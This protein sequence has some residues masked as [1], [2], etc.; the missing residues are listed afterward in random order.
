MKIESIEAIAVD[1]PLKRN[2]GGS[3][4]SVLK[5]STVIT[6]MRTDGG[7]TSE[8]YNGDNREHGGGIGKIGEQ[9]KLVGDRRIGNQPCKPADAR[10]RHGVIGRSDRADHR[11]DE[12]QQIGDHDAP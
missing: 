7:L 5:R 10:L 2:F 8:I 3:T 11:Q 12:E 6:R 4:Y 1:I 9:R